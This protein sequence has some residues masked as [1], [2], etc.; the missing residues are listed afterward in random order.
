MKNSKKNNEI[1]KGGEFLIKETQAQDIF[2]REEFGEDQIMMLNATKEFSEK[3]IRP[4]LM[5]F[6]EKNYEL[7][8]KLMR[9]AG[10]LGL[11]AISVPE[12]YQGLGMGFNTSML[13]CEEISSLTGSIATAFGA[14]TGI[15]TLPILLYGNEEQKKH[16][17]PKISS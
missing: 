17:L 12:K 11:L 9:K 15:G 10:Q 1:L 5:K 3:E 14:H 7:V 16:Y 4:N 13:I 6:E 2:I 8:E